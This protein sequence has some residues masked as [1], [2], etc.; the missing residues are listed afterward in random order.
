MKK[1]LLHIILVF[2]ITKAAICQTVFQETING[3]GIAC[4]NQTF[5]GGFVAGGGTIA[6]IDINGNIQWGKK[7]LVNQITANIYSVIQA[8]DGGY[9]AVG[10]YDS[11]SNTSSYFILKTDVNGNVVWSKT[12]YNN[13][14]F[15]N[16]L[17]IRQT[18][19]KG[20]AI[21]GGTFLGQ[22]GSLQVIKTDSLGNMLWDKVYSQP[23]T[24][25][26]FLGSFIQTNDGGYMMSTD[27]ETQNYTAIL[28]LDN[29]GNI[30]WT[31]MF[32]NLYGGSYGENII[33]TKDKGYVLSNGTLIKLDSLGNIIWEK[34][35]VELPNHFPIYI[36]TGS[37]A[38]LNN[39]GLVY[40][41][42][43]GFALF[44]GYKILVRTDSLGVPQWA[45]TY[46]K[47]RQ[48]FTAA[49]IQGNE[50]GSSGFIASANLYNYTTNN[51][52]E[53]I[54]KTDA[55]GN[56]GCDSN[57]TV[58]DSL[59]TPSSTT[60]LVINVTSGGSL[61]NISAVASSVN[62]TDSV[63]CSATVGIIEI[64]KTNDKISIYPN[65]ASTLI[66]I[67]LKTKNITQASI[68]I[69]NMLGECVYKQTTS[70]TNSQINI[71]DLNAGIYTIEITN[72]N[73]NIVKRFVKQ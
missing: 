43:G 7:Y 24:D 37:S 11:T 17:V 29:Q 66:T 20:Y 48:F 62:V 58:I 27:V 3:A 5:D 64:K 42:D 32:P 54:V 18:T 15:T 52:Q 16:S 26:L 61:S 21:V 63:L 53:V 40:T 44:G 13:P 56:S 65:P 38:G 34:M 68:A 41:Q 50:S 55:N 33:Q 71:A 36:S 4:I 22:A 51:Y 45:K 70:S 59:I 8:Q 67:E 19:D 47:A 35:F 39:S 31:K 10:V 69:Y 72:A 73:Q 12:I 9:A 49:E 60:T 6:K 28:K 23:S 57:I 46:K 2:F 14:M 30:K 1:L 25:D